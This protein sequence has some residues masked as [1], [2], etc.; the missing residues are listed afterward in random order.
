LIVVPSPGVVLCHG[1]KP[2]MLFAE[3]ADRF[4]A[5]IGN[6]YAFAVVNFANPDM[7][8]H[9]GVIPA[10]VAAVEE[11]DRCL[12]RVVDCV[13][14]LGGVCLI[15]ADHGNAEAE[16]EADGVSPQTAHTTT[17]VPLI[18]PTACPL[19]DGGELADLVPPALG[20]L[21]IDPPAEMTGKD[22]LSEPTSLT[23]T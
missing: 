11:T 4:C 7:V 15:T 16:L 14:A 20:L 13:T 22:L 3:V 12:G 2:E 8:G 23:S 17:P 21:G 5:E 10:V 1:H 9:T 19:R 6:D 18:V